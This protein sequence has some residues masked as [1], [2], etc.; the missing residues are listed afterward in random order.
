MKI[1]CTNIPGGD[2]SSL[3][4]L[5]HA[6][7]GGLV[8]CK[9]LLPLELS[10]KGYHSLAAVVPEAEGGWLEHSRPP[11]PA[12]TCESGVREAE[13]QW[14]AQSPACWALATCQVQLM[15]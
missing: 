1:R 8:R 15:P 13:K 3:I 11:A 12:W 5:L 14:A 4:S 10:P 6:L 7:L 9:D 2:F